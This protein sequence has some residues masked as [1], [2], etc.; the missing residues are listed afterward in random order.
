LLRK[1][2]NDWRYWQE[3][4]LPY[5]PNNIVQSS[6][7]ISGFMVSGGNTH[8][9]LIY[10]VGINFDDHTP[11]LMPLLQ[12]ESLMDLDSQNGI[13]AVALKSENRLLIFR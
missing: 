4:S 2:G 11:L 13:A 7:A 8:I 1:E 10:I 6:R 9:R 3:V 5:R 12:S